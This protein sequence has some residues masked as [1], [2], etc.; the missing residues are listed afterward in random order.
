MLSLVHTGDKMSPGDNRSPEHS[1]A[2]ICCRRRQQNVAQIV[3]SV[4]EPLESV[5]GI[6]G[7]V[8]GELRVGLLG[9]SSVTE[10]EIDEE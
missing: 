7:M 1:R 8:S 9:H 5:K 6:H 2:T 4:V 3:A 10:R